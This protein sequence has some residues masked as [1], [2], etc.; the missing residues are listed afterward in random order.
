MRN[1]TYFRCLFFNV[2]IYVIT[3]DILLILLMTRP[4][5]NFVMMIV[6]YDENILY[7]GL[8]SC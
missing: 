6:D 1:F 5:S 7:I 4:L 2:N 3:L 8:A